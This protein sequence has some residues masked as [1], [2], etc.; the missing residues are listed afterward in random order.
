[1]AECLFVQN[2]DNGKSLKNYVP[3]GLAGALVI[4]EKL[5]GEVD[6]FQATKTVENSVSSVQTAQ[7]QL[8]NSED[9][10]N[11]FL[12]GLVSEDETEDTLR[13]KL[14]PLTIGGVKYDEANVRLYGV[15]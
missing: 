7:V 13:T 8:I 14:L 3:C 9:G 5:T 10:T 4:A 11:K 6:V 15:K 12:Q 1:M 2:F